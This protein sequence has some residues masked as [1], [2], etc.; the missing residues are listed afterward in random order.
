MDE[1]IGC[2]KQT[3]L[4]AAVTAQKPGEEA[5][6]DNLDGA[7]DAVTRAWRCLEEEARK[8]VGSW[9]ERK[10]EETTSKVVW[11][12][13]EE[14]LD[15]SPLVSSKLVDVLCVRKSSSECAPRAAELGE[16]ARLRG[17]LGEAS[18]GLAAVMGG[19]AIAMRLLGFSGQGE[20]LTESTGGGGGGGEFQYGAEG[21]GVGVVRWG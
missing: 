7:V 11:I 6:E 17:W 20:A 21:V 16:R 13:E 12:S 2:T 1:E 15:S 4:V 10:R 14:D 3:R 9:L 18:G 8:R 5:D 19:V